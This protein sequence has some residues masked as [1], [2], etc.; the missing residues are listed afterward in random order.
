LTLIITH[1]EHGGCYAHVA[2]GPAVPPGGFS[3]EDGFQF[4]LLGLRVPMVMVSPYIAP[5]T[6]V[7]APREH[8]SFLKTLAIKWGLPTL[9]DRDKAALDFSEV[10]TS[11]L[12]QPASSWP[13]LA[14]HV[15]PQS[16]FTQDFSD[17]PL[18]ELQRSIVGMVAALPQAK[19]LGLDAT[20][21]QTVGNATALIQRVP[22]LP[23]TYPTDAPALLAPAPHGRP[24]A[25]SAA[26]IA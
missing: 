22:G 25:P 15:M 14:D 12:A 16:W 24:S 18:N 9:T 3:R 8:S 13:V 5:G 6:I 23:G 1:D 7:N 2:P 17:A 21:V 19:G 11:D 10:F 4:Y 20:A 26:M